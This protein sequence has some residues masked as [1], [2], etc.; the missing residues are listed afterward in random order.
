VPTRDLEIVN[1]LGLHARPAKEFVETANRFE[2]SVTVRKDDQEVNGKSLVDMMTL[3]ATAGT[4]LT[5]DV[6][7]EDADACLEALEELVRN[8]FDEE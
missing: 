6:E 8:K 3:G 7:G 1:R 4:V 5:L 2:S